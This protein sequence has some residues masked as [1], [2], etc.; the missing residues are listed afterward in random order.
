M[1]I[2][3]RMIEADEVVPWD[4]LNFITGHINYG[5]RVTDD[6]DRRCLISI[7]RKYFRPAIIEDEYRFSVSGKYYA[8]P[9]G[10]LQDL[11]DYLA[12]LPSVDN[13]E[14]FGMHEN[15]NTVYVGLG[16]WG[17]RGL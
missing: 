13:P 12:T 2:L 4:A 3:K 10:T 9:E 7:L 6:Q 8:P 15:A 14:I 1:S 17:G 5:G 16:R 11:N